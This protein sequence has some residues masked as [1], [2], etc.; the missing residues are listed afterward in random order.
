MMNRI[1]HNLGVC[2]CCFCC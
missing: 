2:F 1:S